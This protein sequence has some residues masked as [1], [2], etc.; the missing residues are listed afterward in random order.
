MQ[1]QETLSDLFQE[2]PP[3][4]GWLER[5]WASTGKKYWEETSTGKWSLTHPAL[6]EESQQET[7]CKTEVAPV[8]GVDEWVFVGIL[9]STMKNRLL[10]GVEDAQAT[11]E[12]E[13]FVQ[14]A[15]K[16]TVLW[17]GNKVTGSSVA[18]AVKHNRV[19]WPSMQWWREKIV[20]EELLR[21]GF[22]AY[23]VH[24]FGGGHWEK[25]VVP[26][27]AT[28]EEE[29]QKLLLRWNVTLEEYVTQYNFEKKKKNERGKEGSQESV[30]VKE[31]PGA[32]IGTPTKKRRMYHGIP[33][34]DNHILFALP[35]HEYVADR[36][37][38]G[39]NR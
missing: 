1:S 33:N 32:G 34:P 12:A 35:Y 38:K 24:N 20:E 28:Q 15:C 6:P 5:V 22:G 18:A 7:D 16:A 26:E 36:R 4:D 37:L 3:P 11:W 9:S 21:N 19:P 17:P 39:I 27:D 8:Q 2:A 25:P 31:E 10:A 14:A 13:G 23:S 30:R 29:F